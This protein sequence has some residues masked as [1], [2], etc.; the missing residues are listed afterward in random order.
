MTF[1]EPATTTGANMTTEHPA[2]FKVYT[3]TFGTCLV[4]A[5]FKD[6]LHVGIASLDGARLWNTRQDH[7]MAAQ[8]LRYAAQ[9]F[10]ALA[11]QCERFASDALEGD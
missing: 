5:A 8:E 11:R 7:A 9:Y 10:A 1:I 3:D 4:P 2:A 6:Y